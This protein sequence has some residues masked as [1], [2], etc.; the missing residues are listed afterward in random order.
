MVA[1]QAAAQ[2]DDY[3]SYNGLRDD[4]NSLDSKARTTTM[5]IL[6]NHLVSAWD[7]LMVARGFNAD[8]PQGVNMD[9][10]IS[11]SFSNPGAKVV[12]KRHF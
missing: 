8:L 12:F 4:R 9:F 3:A 11:G 10:K 1:D 5:V 2:D 6:V 7:A